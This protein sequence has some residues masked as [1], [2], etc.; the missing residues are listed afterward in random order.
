M[1]KTLLLIG[2]AV[3]C[4]GSY[5]Q[6]VATTKPTKLALILKETTYDFG[7][8]QQGRSVTHEFE[9]TNAGTDTIRL[10]NV[11]ASCGCTTPVWKADPIAPNKSAKIQVGFNAANEGFFEK[12]VNIFYNNNQVKSVVIKGNVYK[13]PPCSAPANA[14]VLLLKQAN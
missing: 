10:Q 8:I 11:Q 2:L 13:A 9:V 1:K 7:K 4:L 3:C 12:S 6:N 5:A 14:S